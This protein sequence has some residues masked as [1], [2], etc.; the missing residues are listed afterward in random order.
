[1]WLG[2]TT[3]ALGPTITAASLAAVDVAYTQNFDTLASTGTSSAVPTG[4]G[5]D[6]TGTSAA[7]NGSYAAGTG[8]GNA[9]DAYSFGAA[10]SSERALGQLRSGTA[11][12]VIGGAFVNNSPTAFT[13]I[14]LSYAGEQWRLGAVGRTIPEQMDFQISVDATSLTTGTWV[15]V[16]ALDF[17]PP[18]TTGTP[19]ALVGNDAANRKTITANIS[20][21][22]IAPGATLWIRWLDVD[23]SGADDGLAIDD[24]SL[25]PH[26]GTVS[27]SLSGTGAASP[28]SVTAGDPTLLTVTV[29]PGANPPSTGITVLADLSAIGGNAIRPFV[30]DG[31]NGDAA[32]NDRIFSLAATVAAATAGGNKALTFTISDAQSRTGT[33]SIALTVTRPVTPIHDIQG[34]GPVSPLTGQVTT[35]GIITG[36]KSNGY[37]IQAPVAEYDMNA[38]TSE[39]IF[40]FT[41]AAGL[42]ATA[43]TGT[44]VRVTG[45]IS[46]FGTAGDPVG[47]SITELTSPTTTV[48]ATGQ[49][50][51]PAITLTN[52][53]LFPGASF[54]RLEKY[55]S[56]R[57]HLDTVVSVT[58]TDGTVNEPNAT[59]TST[60]LFFAVLPG[61]A[62]P[63]REPGIQ[64]P[65]PVPPEA[66][67]GATPPVFDGNYEHIG[68]DSY[69]VFETA[70]L[71]RIT[72]PPANATLEVT[73]GVTVTNVT[74]PLDYSFRLYVV[75]AENW[76]P[77]V[78]T[79]PNRALG[80]ASPAGPGQ[81]SVASFN[82]ERFFD[83]SD[84][85]G[86]DVVLSQT[87]FNGRLNK[88]SLAIRTVLGMPDILGVEEVENLATLEAIAAK[89]NADAMAGSQG[90]PQYRAFLDEGNDPGGID[91]GFLVRGD[92]VDLTPGAFTVTQYGKATTFVQPDGASAL[93]NDRPPLVLDARILNPPFEAYPV[94]VIVNHLR[95]LNDVEGSDATGARVRAKRRSQA[96]FLAALIRSFQDQG[97]HV[98]S[99]GDYNAFDVNDGYVD[100][101]GIVRGTPAPANEVT[102]TT[103]LLPNQLPSPPLVDAIAFAPA[104]QRYSYVFDGNAQEIDHVLLTAGML[105]NRIEYGRMDA[106]FPVSY[107]GDFT[108]PERL[109]DHDPIVVIFN[110]PDIDTN[111][112]ALT[113]PDDIALEGNTTGGALVTYVASAF[114]AVDGAVTPVCAPASSSLFRVGTT[115]V[116]CTA[117]DT[118]GNFSTGSFVVTVN[119]TTAPAVTSTM[120]SP[121]VLWPANGSMVTVHV[122]VDASD[123]VSDTT[124][125]ISRITGNDGATAADWEITGKLT[126]RL[127]AERSGGGHGRTYTLTVKT[128]DE[129]GNTTTSTTTVV[130]PHDQGRR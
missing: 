27:T 81:F 35:E 43:V 88:A 48:L 44:R 111:P 129:A 114:D 95:S 86:S 84:G 55:E 39:G 53:D 66:P 14:D 52:T 105:V 9:G 46:E 101:V 115:T 82:M 72:T 108:R 62:R 36:V 19:G 118:H 103:E 4:W 125:H 93:L 10:S 89:V 34:S 8:S 74:G 85:P 59:S 78:A 94:T 126:A 57:V 38:E 50:L 47:L 45:T 17:S 67:A 28:S 97:K 54:L 123:I 30:D 91:S 65:L 106:V 6:E 87:A 22:N 33:G 119:D 112:P 23:A 71:A 13:N 60:G 5:F 3:F 64:A 56:M 31:S 92:R 77:P 20:G 79:T 109:S 102:L 41:T 63:F 104:D 1:M 116:S 73:T 76:N 40:V 2:R 121:S 21:L 127:R 124:S 29:T 120:P 49:A 68:V 25:T 107:R 11:V 12:V 113:L 98:V 128:K 18:I 83:T 96:D 15:D 117:T 37:F 58:P 7:V 26:G 130:V 69:S 61:A 122:T 16:N 75:D 24:V 99:V 90:N 51:P 100:V 42:P 80:T 110:T 70:T 32:P